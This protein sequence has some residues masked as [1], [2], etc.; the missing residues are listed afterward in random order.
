[1][2]TYKITN[3]TNLAGKRDFKYNSIL[4]IDY[5]DNMIKKNLEVKP[6]NTVYL[7]IQTLPL[8]IHRLRIKNLI[9]VNEISSTELTSLYN[10]K[11]QIIKS[12]VKETK[13]EVKKPLVVNKKKTLKTDGEEN[14]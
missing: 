9:T 3:I 2:N 10:P 14:I 6:G 1:M 7:T 11:P 8:S 12:E 5:I 13:I 4:N